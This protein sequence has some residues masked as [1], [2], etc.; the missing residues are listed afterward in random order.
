MQAICTLDKN[1]HCPH[2]NADWDGGAI[3][4]SLRQQTHFRLLNDAELRDL[5]SDC[6]GNAAGRW[7]RLIG[8]EVQGR[9]DGVSFWQCPDCQKMW[10]ARDVQ[11]LTA[12]DD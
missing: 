9:Y 12:A 8:V 2:C 4:D 11:F 3:F 6:Y 1:G 7:S 5:I 10:P